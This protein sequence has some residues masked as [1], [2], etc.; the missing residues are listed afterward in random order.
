MIKVYQVSRRYI[1]IFM[2]VPN[3]ACSVLLPGVCRKD[4]QVEQKLTVLSITH[5]ERVISMPNVVE[6]GLERYLTR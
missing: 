3:V 5:V 6:F 1:M 2:H 4:R